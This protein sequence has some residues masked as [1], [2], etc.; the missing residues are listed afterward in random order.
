M[1]VQGKTP[2]SNETTR[3]L[4]AI[5]KPTNGSK[6][7]CRMRFYY[8]LHG[9]RPSIVSVMLKTSAAGT[10]GKILWRKSGK[11]LFSSSTIPFR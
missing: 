8:H 9:T 1:Y 2:R 5:F 7:Q 6:G 11:S 4:S 3:L 10:G